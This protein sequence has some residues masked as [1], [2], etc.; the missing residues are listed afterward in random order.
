MEKFIQTHA[1]SVFSVMDAVNTPEQLIDKAVEKGHAAMCLTDHGAYGG[2]VRFQNYALSKGVKP[3]I[4]VEG[5]VVKDLVK[6]DEKGKRIREKNNHIILHAMNKEGWE[7][8]LYL[9]YISEHD[10]DHFYYKPRFSFKELFEHSKGLYV[11]TACIASPFSNL[12]K[13]NRQE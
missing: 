8:L 5:Y 6:E 7:N 10:A 11:G 9:N 2:L 12:L 1:H 3:I 4:G 13:L